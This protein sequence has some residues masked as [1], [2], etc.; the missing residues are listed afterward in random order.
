MSKLKL[1]ISHTR[2]GLC[3][4]KTSGIGF[5]FCKRTEGGF[6]TVMPI[7]PCLDYAHE[8]IWAEKTGSPSSAWGFTAKPTGCFKDEMILAFQMTNASKTKPAQKEID[9]LD[10]AIE[11]LEKFIGRIELKIEAINYPTHLYKCGENEFVAV[12]SNWWVSR[13]YLV[14]L[15]GKLIRAAIK[16]RKGDPIEYLKAFK[17]AERDNISVYLPKLEKIFKGV[18]PEQDFKVGICPHDY[19]IIHQEFPE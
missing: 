14:S 4:G 6:E 10:E 18:L 19:G 13:T 12:A 9:S 11:H 7:S 8:Q 3:E 16:Y 1:K 5:G 15:Y 17:G 2:Q